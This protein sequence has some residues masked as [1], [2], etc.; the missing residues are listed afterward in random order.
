[1]S[2]VD[3]ILE[4]D[5]FKK[6]LKFIKPYKHIFIGVLVAV[7]LLAI[8]GALR[9]YILQQAIDQKIATKTFEG[10]LPYILIMAALLIAEVVCQ[11]LFIYYSGFLGQSV[12]KDIRASSLII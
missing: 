12:V 2:K 4:I 9:P 11:L 8:F 6:L 1:M 10:F 7:I 5:L 3:T